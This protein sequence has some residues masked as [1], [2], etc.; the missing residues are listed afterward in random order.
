MSTKYYSINGYGINLT[1]I[2]KKYRDLTFGDLE[3]F[4]RQDKMTEDDYTDYTEFM[5][6][7]TLD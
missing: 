2:R 4:C 5:N 1:D 7:L 6:A 3:R